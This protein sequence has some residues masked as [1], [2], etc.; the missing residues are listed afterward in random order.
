MDSRIVSYPTRRVKRLGQGA[1]PPGV[2]RHPSGPGAA[3]LLV[4][5]PLVR[6]SRFS[7][8]REDRDRCFH[9]A[10]GLR[11]E[12]TERL[13][14]TEMLFL[15]PVYFITA[16]LVRLSSPGPVFYSH[17]RIGIHGKPFTMYKF[18]SMFENAENGKPQLSRDNDPRITGFGKF[19]RKTRLDEIPQFYNVLKG[20]MSLVGPRPERNYFIEQIVKVAPH[21]KHLHKVRPGITSWGMVKFGYAENVEQML[22][23]MK[24]DLIYIENMTLAVDFK[25]LI[26]T[27]LTVMRGKGK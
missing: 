20:D 13:Q 1:A 9:P 26:Y 25:I 12:L 8:P 15:S 14:F 4:F 21:Y 11:I 17:E 3:P 16:I 18:R 2:K 24:Y 10:G 23:R 6:S 5:H 27:V 7:F 22:E 19:M